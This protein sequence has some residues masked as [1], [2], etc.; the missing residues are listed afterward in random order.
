LQGHGSQD[1]RQGNIVR[2]SN[3]N[4]APL[5]QADEIYLQS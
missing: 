3:Q 5:Q 2:S 1:Q 4:L